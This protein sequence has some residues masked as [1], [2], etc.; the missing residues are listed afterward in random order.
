[1]NYSDPFGL[2]PSWLGIAVRAAFG[3]ASV[4]DNTVRPLE[5]KYVQ[6]AASES[7]IG[8]IDAD[9]LE[10]LGEKTVKATIGKGA[11]AGLRRGATQMATR[12]GATAA[13]EG[14]A[15]A[16]GIGAGEAVGVGVGAVLMGVLST[17][18]ILLVTTST[19]LKQ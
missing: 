7:E 9:A 13:A 3:I 4:A 17:V 6:E 2:T 5:P 19:D 12:A 8:A 11:K 15:E 14:G 1:M 18:L 10:N 16:V